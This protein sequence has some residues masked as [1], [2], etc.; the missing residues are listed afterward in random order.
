[1]IRLISRLAEASDTPPALAAEQ[2]QTVVHEVLVKLRSGKPATIP[3]LGTFL[4]GAA[5][6]F[7]NEKKNEKRTQQRRP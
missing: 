2:I 5:V 7:K 4:P 1:M 6:R 3:G